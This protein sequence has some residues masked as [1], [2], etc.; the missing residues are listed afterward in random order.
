MFTVKSCNNAINSA[1]PSRPLM[2]FAI[3]E[4][5][6]S[7]WMPL[8]PML[9]VQSFGTPKTLIISA[10]DIFAF[11]F[12]ISETLANKSVETSTGLPYSSL[13]RMLF[14]ASYI[15]D[16]CAKGEDFG[17]TRGETSIFFPFTQAY[18]FSNSQRLTKAFCDFNGR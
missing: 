13:K 6:V 2:A 4:K 9:L 3:V 12:N 18:L 15:F 16:H 7:P 8:S 14:T 10:D 11:H 17:V 1:S 5:V